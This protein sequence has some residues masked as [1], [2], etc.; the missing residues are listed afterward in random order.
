MCWSRPRS[1][2][3]AGTRS[4]VV[5][6]H[7]PQTASIECRR[8]FDANK[9]EKPRTGR[10]FSLQLSVGRDQIVTTFEACGPL[11]P[12]VTSN[13]TFWPSARLLKP[14]PVS[15]LKCTNTSLPPSSCEIKPKPFASL[16]HFTVPV[17]VAIISLLFQLV[18][19][20]GCRNGG[21]RCAAGAP[22]TAREF[23]KWRRLKGSL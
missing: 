3:E 20:P 15:A 18:C 16:N 12:S 8:H 7:A 23:R 4:G 19:K 5:C 2:R 9:K 6:G 14:E 17:V 22:L 11:A 1:G 10:G 21:A 13:W